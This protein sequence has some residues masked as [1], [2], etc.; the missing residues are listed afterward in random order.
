VTNGVGGPETPEIHL[1]EAYA[2]GAVRGGGGEAGDLGI[3]RLEQDEEL[4]HCR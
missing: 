1:G 3:V 2:S 4:G